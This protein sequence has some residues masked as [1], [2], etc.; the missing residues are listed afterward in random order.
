M[1][2]KDLKKHRFPTEYEEMVLNL[3]ETYGSLAE[4]KELAELLGVSPIALNG[5]LRTKKAREAM[6][7][8][9]PDAKK[10]LRP[11]IQLPEPTTQDLALLD[12]SL[13]GMHIIESEIPEGLA[14]AFSTFNKTNDKDD[15]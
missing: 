11:H 8:A 7:K 10:L 14:S 13:H 2:R 5:F 3:L 12:D 9:H 15:D 6:T 1:A 4:P